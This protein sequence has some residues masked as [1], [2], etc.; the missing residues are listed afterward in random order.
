[1]FVDDFDFDFHFHFHFH[2][3]FYF[4]FY[5]KQGYGSVVVK[6]KSISMCFIIFGSKNGLY[7]T[8]LHEYFSMQRSA[9][10]HFKGPSYELNMYWRLTI[11]PTAQSIP[12]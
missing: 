6:H 12:R 8:H 11:R 3:H 7:W 4:H 1:M 5:K 10:G 9:P 2:F